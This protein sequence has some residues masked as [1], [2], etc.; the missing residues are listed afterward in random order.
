MD[1]ALCAGST[2]S[3]AQCLGRPVPA[4][5]LGPLSE[6]QLAEGTEALRHRLAEE[7]Y[8]FLRGL[9]PAGEVA[10]AR[11]AI[12]RRLAEVDEVAPPPDSGIATGR[13]RRRELNPDLGAFWKSVSEEGALR[14][15]THGPELSGLGAALFGEPARAQDYLFLRCAGPGKATGVHCDSPFF[16]RMT[17]R[18]ITCWLAIGPVPLEQGPVFVLAGS[19]RSQEVQARFR[20]FDLMRQ[21]DRKATY[22]EDALELAERHGWRIRSADFAPGDVVLFGMFT[23]HGAFDNCSPER[24]VRVSCD[25]RLQPAADPSDPR[26]F[27]P[28]PSGTTGAGYGELNAARPMTEDW[29]IR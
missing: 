29:H 8:L 24:R 7:G 9:L 2:A 28:D 16:T 21:R 12:L 25:V 26:Y 1:D 20:G 23:L 4:A 14:R 10:C 13:S 3:R 17:D 22:S 27:G 11:T 15:L 5:R 18:V 19:H 6:S